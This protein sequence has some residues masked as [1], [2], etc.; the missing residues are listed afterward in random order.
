MRDSPLTWQTTPVRL[1]PDAKMLPLLR[2]GVAAAPD[3][4]DLKIQL[5]VALHGTGRLDELVDWLRPAAGDEDEAP[6]LLMCLSD[7]ALALR[8]YQLALTAARSAAA[9]GFKPAVALLAETLSRLGHP[10]EALK[11]GLEALERSPADARAFAVVAGLLL[12]RNE[13]EQLWVLCTDLR[14]QGVWGGHIPSAMALA[15]RTAEQ[16]DEITQLVDPARWFC[17]T[18]LA[19]P[20]DFNERLA[21]ELLAHKFM[22]RL[23]STSAAR[24]ASSWILQLE[25]VG[26]PLAQELLTML[27]EAAGTYL[28][29]RQSL[30]DHPMVALRPSSVVLSS[31]ALAVHDDGRT[32]WHRHDGWLT[33]IYY[34]AVPTVEP[35]HDERAGAIE[36]GLL[37]FG[38]EA[39]TLRSP[40][41]QVTPEPGLL[42]LFPS[43]LA[44]RTWPTGVGDP[45]ICVPFD[46]KP[47]KTIS[48]ERARIE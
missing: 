25:L 11:A 34:V 6:E 31:L 18:R 5:A 14:A 42:L 9:Q 26:G 10:D 3:R 22:C 13:T 32:M 36:F 16:D 30:G 40:R 2:M 46:V 39:E 38:R 24:G 45:R 15:A 37:P 8:D 27:R 20:A 23:P 47:A 12:D 1:A 48:D 7:A 43:Y 44:H 29:E 4:P 28:A 41:W 17:A 33:G 19:M 21:A 35:C